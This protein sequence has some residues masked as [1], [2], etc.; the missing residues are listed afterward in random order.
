[1]SSTAA[2]ADTSIGARVREE[3]QRT[4][5]RNIKGLNHIWSDEPPL[6]VTPKDTIYQRGTQALYHYR[7]LAKEV[8][9][10]PVLFVMSLVS[11]P[12]ILDL[13]AGQSFIEF[14]LKQGC[15]VYLIDWGVPR[16]E[17]S[18]LRLDDYVLDFAPDC[19]TRIL[20]DSGEPDLSIIGYCMGGLLTLMYAALH[21]QGPLK[22]LVCLTTPVNFEGMKLMRQWNG[23][24][25]LRGDGVQTRSAV[26]RSGEGPGRPQARPLDTGP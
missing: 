21:P 6:G 22:N 17:D 19:I 10:V 1:M 11:K 3:V 16:R 8:Y 15:D 24:T 25:L 9:R 13:A 5:Q 14:L 18:H 7:P 4:I 12:Y 26:A 23:Q 20:A 2:A